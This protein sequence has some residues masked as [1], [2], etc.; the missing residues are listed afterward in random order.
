MDVFTTASTT[1]TPTAAPAA[2][3]DAQLDITGEVVTGNTSTDE[4]SKHQP[5]FVTGGIGKKSHCAD[6]FGSWRRLILSSEKD[7]YLAE[8]TKHNIIG[9]Q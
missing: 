8:A 4:S 9:R 6:A 1:T 2:T 5:L 7:I 3:A